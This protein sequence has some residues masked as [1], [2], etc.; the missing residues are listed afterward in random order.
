[1]SNVKKLNLVFTFKFSTKYMPII[2]ESHLTGLRVCLK[3]SSDVRII[4]LKS[5][6]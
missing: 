1:M 3:L 6:E 4:N 5:N 2:K